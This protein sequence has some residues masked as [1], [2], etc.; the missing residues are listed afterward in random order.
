VVDALTRALAL[1]AKATAVVTAARIIVDDNDDFSVTNAA[2]VTS[3]V[4]S[5]RAQRDSLIAQVKP[6]VAGWDG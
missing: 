6:V 2:Q 1:D 5:K 4:A 3:Y